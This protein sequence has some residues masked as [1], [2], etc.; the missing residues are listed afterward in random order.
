M[1]KV[2]LPYLLPKHFRH[3]GPERDESQHAL[4]YTVEEYFEDTTIVGLVTQAIVFASHHHIG[5]YIKSGV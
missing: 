5:P 2:V 1:R 3:Q 4:P